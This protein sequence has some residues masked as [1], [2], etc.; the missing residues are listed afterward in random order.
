MKDGSQE[1]YYFHTLNIYDK[2]PFHG[3]KA[4][5]IKWVT[6]FLLLV[7]LK[8]K[9][10]EEVDDGGSKDDWFLQL[11]PNNPSC[12]KQFYYHTDSHNWLRL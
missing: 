10:R 3:P 11:L 2:N 7:W 4:S 1:C 6:S 9:G 8:A 12:L 5:W